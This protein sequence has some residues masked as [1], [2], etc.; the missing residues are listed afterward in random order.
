MSDD[1]NAEMVYKE[2]GNLE[3][4]TK[5]KGISDTSSTTTLDWIRSVIGNDRKGMKRGRVI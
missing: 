2:I 3:D 5:R 1:T 4:L